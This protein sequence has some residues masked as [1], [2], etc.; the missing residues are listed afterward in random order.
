MTQQ[1]TITGSLR[2]FLK[3]WERRRTARFIASLPP[4]L[5]KDIGWPGT[6]SYLESRRCQP[7]ATD[8]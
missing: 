1:R 8:A 2:N 3:N 6:R 4:E 7:C 5:R